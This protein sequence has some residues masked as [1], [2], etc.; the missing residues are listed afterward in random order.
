M[1]C[2]HK[3][4]LQIPKFGG[5]SASPNQR[6]LQIGKDNN[7]NM[8][9]KFSYKSKQNVVWCT[10]RN[11]LRSG[12]LFGLACVPMCGQFTQQGLK[13]LGTG[14]LS[15]PSHG[16]AVAIS[17]DGTTAGPTLLRGHLPRTYRPPWARLPT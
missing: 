11:A 14:A 5:L 1:Q 9:R 12:F 10:L 8:R 4:K 2:V 17:A 13:L 3:A 15:D 6:I 7:Q 16:G